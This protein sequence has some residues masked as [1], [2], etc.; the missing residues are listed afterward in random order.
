MP[1][2]VPK[3]TSNEAIKA[4]CKCGFALDRI[5]GSHHILRH[6]GKTQHLSIPVHGNKTVAPVCC[7]VSSRL[8]A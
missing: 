1:N 3:I 6:P 5:R 4:F 7:G 2:K 8:L